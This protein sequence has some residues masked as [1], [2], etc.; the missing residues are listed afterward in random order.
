MMDWVVVLRILHVLLAAFWAG[1]IFFFVLFVE[2]SV[3]SLG[4]DGGRVVRALQER[5][6]L[7]ILIVAAVL[8]VVLGLIVLWRFTNNFSPA[9]MSSSYGMS[10][11]LGATAGLLTLGLGVF[12]SRPTLQ[13]LLAKGAE[14]AA[15]GGPPSEAD[16]SEIARLQSR[17]R[18][19]ARSAA[20]LLL[21][22][23]VFMA[24]AKYV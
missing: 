24:A 1:S 6:F 22:A 15:R 19:A 16:Q 21:L 3:R 10:L 18:V 8:T 7:D 14:V 20:V 9:V 13:R 17:L 5:H 2:P 11:M 12:V 23:I 4:P